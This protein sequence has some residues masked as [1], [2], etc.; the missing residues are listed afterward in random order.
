MPGNAFFDTSAIVPLCVAEATSLRARQAYRRMRKQVVA[1][2]TFVEATGAFYRALGLGGLS[3][4]DAQRALRHLDLLEE[5]WI[6][7]IPT[8]RVRGIALEV[9]RIH[10]LRAGDAVQLAS[11]LVWCKE[12]PRRRSFICFDEKLSIA[13][14]S[15]G[16]DVLR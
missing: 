12:R 14:H 2:T 7:I 3:D 13:A 1:W 10:Q 6:E 5:R 8:E 15:L 4:A 9:L 16:F 11:A